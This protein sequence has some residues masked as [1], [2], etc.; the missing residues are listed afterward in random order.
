[1]PGEMST[2]ALIPGQLNVFR[3]VGNFGKICS[4]CLYNTE[5]SAQNEE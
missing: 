2:S 1:M 3:G 4:A 5:F